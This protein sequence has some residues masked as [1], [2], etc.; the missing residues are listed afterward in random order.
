MQERWGAGIPEVWLSAKGSASGF[1]S[2]PLNY[3]EWKFTAMAAGVR[4]HGAG[5]AV[6]QR[7]L[8]GVPR[9]GDCAGGVAPMTTR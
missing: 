3:G 5:P 2:R 1:P 6:Q 7:H 8:G 9:L 4:K